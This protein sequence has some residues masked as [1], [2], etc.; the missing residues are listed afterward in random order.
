MFMGA[1]NES[2][3]DAVFDRL[4]EPSHGR[5]DRQPAKRSFQCLRMAAPYDGILMPPESAYCQIRC[6]ELSTDSIS[7]YSAVRLGAGRFIFRLSDRDEPAVLLAARVIDCRE[8]AVD[9]SHRFLVTCLF[10]KRMQ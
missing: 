2:Q 6:C 3:F 8:D 1:L 4:A 7:F 10:T 9:D 5:N